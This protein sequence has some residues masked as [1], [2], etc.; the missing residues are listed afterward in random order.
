MNYPKT[1]NLDL[2]R[3]SK[4]PGLYHLVVKVA[5]FIYSS[6]HSTR[7]LFYQALEFEA[8]LNSLAT[9]PYTG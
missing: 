6:R 1:F 8:A 3:N 4:S 5:F 9:L 2:P 7:R